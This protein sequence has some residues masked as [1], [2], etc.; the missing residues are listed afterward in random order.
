MR[1]PLNIIR[2]HSSI[3]IYLM[4]SWVAFKRWLLHKRDCSLESSSSLLLASSLM[5]ICE[6][7]SPNYEMFPCYYYKG[8]SSSVHQPANL[9]K[10]MAAATDILKERPFSPIKW[11]RSRP[12]PSENYV[13]LKITER[14]TSFDKAHSRKLVL[15]GFTTNWQRRQKFSSNIYKLTCIFTL[16]GRMERQTYL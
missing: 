4:I 9:L 10:V 12:K 7:M 14:E 2:S 6:L 13:N 5:Q 8:C 11:N 15:F 1:K 16:P 3:T